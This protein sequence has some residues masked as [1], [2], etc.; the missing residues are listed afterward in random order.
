MLNYGRHVLEERRAG[1]AA[2]L[3][4]PGASV[5]ALAEVIAYPP[6]DPVPEQ[7]LGYRKRPR[8]DPDDWRR[9]SRGH[10]ITH[11]SGFGLD[12]CSWLVKEIVWRISPEAEASDLRREL[13]TGAP[14]TW[15]QPPDLRKLSIEKWPEGIFLFVSRNFGPTSRSK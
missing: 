6:G 2:P 12:Y 5:R 10:S 15:A 4:L 7:L 8:Y 9:R 13:H 3:W 14:P 1:L 11:L